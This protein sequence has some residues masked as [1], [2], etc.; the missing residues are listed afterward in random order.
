MTD[1]LGLFGRIGR[2][3]SRIWARWRLA[4]GIPPLSY[5]WGRDRG[6]PV[7]R[8]YVNKFLTEFRS[9]I[10]GHCLEFNDPHYVTRF[11]GS[12]VSRLDVLHVDESNP[13]AT[14]VADLTRANDLPSDQFDCIVCT[15]VLHVIFDVRTAVSEMHRILKPGGILLVAV[16]HISMCGPQFHEIWRF[17]PEGLALVLAESFGSESVT[18]NPYGNSLTAAGDLR[19]VIADEF[20]NAEL[21]THDSRFAVEVCGRAVKHSGGR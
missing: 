18:I 14:L 16:P 6:L 11:G 2:R 1:R 12:A 21:D 20:T 17:T 8:Y 19:G 4:N 5:V 9:D 10:Q 15:H 7:H 3:T 13:K